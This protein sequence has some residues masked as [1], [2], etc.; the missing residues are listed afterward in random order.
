[1]YD[2]GKVIMP[3]LCL[4][5][6]ALFGFL[7]WHERSTSGQTMPLYATA[8]VLSPSF[9]TYTL[10]AMKGVNEALSQKALDSK[11][12]SVG[13]ILLEAVAEAKGEDHTH[14]L[15]DQWGL[16]NLVRAGMIGFAGVLAL[17]A[18]VSPM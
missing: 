7:A 6:T 16:H 13:D 4:V 18:S 2:Q 11:T 9:V 15:A 1:M 10:L 5:P 17:W 3:P 14:D 12:E 8:A